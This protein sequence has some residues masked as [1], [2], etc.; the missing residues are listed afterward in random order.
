MIKDIQDDLTSVVDIETGL[1]L[2]FIADVRFPPNDFHAD[3]RFEGGKVDFDWKKKD[4]KVHHTHYDFQGV[5]AHDS[6]SAMAAVRTWDAAP[7]ATRRLVIVGGRRIWQ[8]DVTW[9]GRETI[10]TALGNVAAV[11][12]DGVS[13]RVSRTLHAE[14]GKDPRTFSVWLSDDGD[15]VPL[16]VVAHTELGDVVIELTGYERP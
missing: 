5:D 3:G 14:V 10:G 11:R 6:H 2:T 4:D 12:L 15:R 13:Q 1:P 7:G 16:R 8:T 9:T